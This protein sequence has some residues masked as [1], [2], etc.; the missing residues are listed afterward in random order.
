MKLS[1]LVVKQMK[2]G[3]DDGWFFI[4]EWDETK[5]LPDDTVEVMHCFLDIVLLSSFHR[6]WNLQDEVIVKQELKLSELLAHLATGYS[7]YVSAIS[8]AP[9]N[10]FTNRADENIAGKQLP[11]HGPRSR[12]LRPEIRKAAGEE[13]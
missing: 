6:I 9:Q 7:I 1:Y 2:K 12:G 8:R 13:S 11:R 3:S 4:E 10:V 5:T